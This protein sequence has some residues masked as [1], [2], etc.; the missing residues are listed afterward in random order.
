MYKYEIGGIDGFAELTVDLGEGQPIK[1]EAGVMSYMDGTIQMETKSGGFFSGLKRSFS[2]ESFFQNAFTGP[3][4]ITFAP[5]LPI[6]PKKSNSS[7]THV[8]FPFILNSRR[9]SGQR[10]YPPSRAL[11]ETRHAE[12]RRGASHESSAQ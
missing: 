8:N 4:K 9:N 7:S 10:S 6:L 1:A 2:G 11:K 3:G 5:I 12:T